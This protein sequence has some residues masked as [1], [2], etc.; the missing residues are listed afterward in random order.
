MAALL[1]GPT[2][3]AGAAAAQYVTLGG[4]DMDAC[5]SNGRVAGLNPRGDNFLAVR[6]GPGTRHAQ[7]DSL[8]MGDAVF[9]CSG[10][11]DWYGIVY[12]GGRDCGVSSPVLPRQV[13]RGPCKSGWVHRSFIEVTA[14]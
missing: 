5:A 12:G 10:E 9:L 14:G 6:S 11:G 1:L 13:Y 3:L 7:I 4:D 2:S 8:H